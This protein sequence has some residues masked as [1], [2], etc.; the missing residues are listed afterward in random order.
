MKYLQSIGSVN[1]IFECF[2]SFIFGILCDYVNLKYLLLFIIGV[3]TFISLT[4]CFTFNNSFLFFLVTNFVSFSAGGYYPLQ[5][6]YLMKVFGTFIY[7]ELNS[8]VS[9][10]TAFIVT[11]MTPIAYFIEAKIEIKDNAYWIL[12]IG[13]G[14][15]NLIGTI[16]G[17]FIDETPFNFKEKIQKR[18]KIEEDEEN[19]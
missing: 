1:F 14:I 13:L 9:F 16:L 12:F 2:S 6:C 5:D 17:L 4:Y 15:L 7:I 11:L 10:L 18:K 8:Y 3:D 19:A